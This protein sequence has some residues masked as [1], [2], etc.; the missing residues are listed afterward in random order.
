[1]KSAFK[2]VPEACTC[3]RAR[4]RGTE[5]RT[6]AH[7]LSAHALGQR[8]A[9]FAARGA[10]SLA[11]G[12][13]VTHEKRMPPLRKLFSGV[14]V[15]LVCALV[16]V[17]WPV[18]VGASGLHQPTQRSTTK[19][20]IR[21]EISSADLKEDLKTPELPKPTESTTTAHGLALP[22]DAHGLALPRSTATHGFALPGDDAPAN[23]IGTRMP[24]VFR[25]NSFP[26][27]APQINVSESV[28]YQGQPQSRPT[29]GKS[30]VPL[31]RETS[32]ADLAELIPPPRSPS[33]AAIL[34]DPA[35]AAAEQELK[36][37][38]LRTS[39]IVVGEV[40]REQEEAWLSR[41]KYTGEVLGVGGTHS[42]MVPFYVV[43]GLRL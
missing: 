16:A 4:S 41:V 9:H 14:T 25:A 19:L 11:N 18:A 13:R 29:C 34:R 20:G 17:A 21:R 10:S 15:R 43:T 7:A 24:A 8:P 22:G 31:R 38:V 30:F 6:H 35:T 42:L 37:L 36:N 5:W 33:R 40:S 23:Q 3:R 1:M 26:G 28:P 12:V 2:E 32:Q 39:G 27:P